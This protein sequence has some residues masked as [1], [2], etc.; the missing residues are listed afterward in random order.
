MYNVSPAVDT[1]IYTVTE[2]SLLKDQITREYFSVEHVGSNSSLEGNVY[3]ILATLFEN[4]KD[5]SVAD[6]AREVL[7]KPSWIFSILI[8]FVGVI[9]NIMTIRAIMY[10]PKHHRTAHLKFIISLAC[11]DM[12][13]LVAIFSGDVIYIF[14][15]LHAD[16][17]KLLKTLL[18]DVPLLATLLNLLAMALDHYLA[19]FRQLHYPHL[20]TP[21]RGNCVICAIWVFSVSAVMTEVLIGLGSGEKTFDSICMAIV[22]DSY[23]IEQVIIFTIF[24]VLTVIILIYIRVYHRVTKSSL[25]R[26]R[27]RRQSVVTTMLFIGTFILFWTPEGI[28]HIYMYFKSKIDR[29]YIQDNHETIAIVNDVLFLILQLNSLADPVIYAIGLPKVKQGCKAAFCKEAV[30]RKRAE[31]YYIRVKQTNCTSISLSIL[32]HRQNTSLFSK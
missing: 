29:N 2:K 13:I 9:A 12:F 18:L 27:R 5:S 30:K 7:N 32:A 19:M 4:A 1:S 24:V 8:F 28:F 21:S 6:K 25:S 26:T 23:S 10:V 31:K 3:D 14:S 17:N 22:Y 16:C 15:S 20:M 11:S